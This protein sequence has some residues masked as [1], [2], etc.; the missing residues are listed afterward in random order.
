[1]ARASITLAL[2]ALLAVAFV[3]EVS[4]QKKGPYCRTSAYKVSASTVEANKKALW[5]ACASK[6]KVTAVGGVTVKDG[7]A[8]IKQQVSDKGAWEAYSACEK[9]PANAATYG[10]LKK[11]SDACKSFQASGAC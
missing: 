1:M 6:A 2:C 5:D 11:G 8:L 4:A 9:D 3:A 10:A 7:C